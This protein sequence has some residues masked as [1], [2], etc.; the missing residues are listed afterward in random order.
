MDLSKH[1]IEYVYVSR[2]DFQDPTTM[3]MN[4]DVHVSVGVDYFLVISWPVKARHE[5]TSV[6]AY[7]KRIATYMHTNIE[8]CPR[9]MHAHSI[10]NSENI[11]A[12]L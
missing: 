2:V 12:K 3:T 6:Y 8:M 9:E 1:R 4:I 10:K 7:A 11:Q 5:S